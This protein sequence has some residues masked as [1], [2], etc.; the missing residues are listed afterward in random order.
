MYLIN[1]AVND[2]FKHIIYIIQQQYLRYKN[3]QPNGYFYNKQKSS[4]S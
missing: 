3:I 1:Y 4:T 2:N